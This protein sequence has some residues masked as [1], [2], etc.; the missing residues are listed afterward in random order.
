MPS[1]TLFCGQFPVNA[2]AISPITGH[3]ITGAVQQDLVPLFR[4]IPLDADKL[5]RELCFHP[6]QGR[7]RDFWS[8]CG[9]RLAFVLSALSLRSATKNMPSA[10]LHPSVIDQYLL[11]K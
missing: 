9:F 7:F 10:S 5:Q 11:T 4:V 6:D 3:F 8:Y 1:N 2:A